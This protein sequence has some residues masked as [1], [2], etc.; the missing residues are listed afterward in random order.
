[1]SKMSFD[2]SLSHIGYS[3]SAFEEEREEAIEATAAPRVGVRAGK[4]LSSI[5]PAW[6]GKSEW[7]EWWRW[8]ERRVLLGRSI[9]VEND[10]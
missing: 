3:I 7:K 2:S 5:I 1:M 8:R 9:S 6:D 10:C 4:K